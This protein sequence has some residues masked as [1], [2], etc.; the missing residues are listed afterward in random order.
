MRGRWPAFPELWEPVAKAYGGELLI[1][2][3]ASDVVLCGGKD[4]GPELV[5]KAN[6]VM[7]NDERP[8]SATIFRWTPTGWDVVAQPAPISPTKRKRER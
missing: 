7:L 2:V 4:S 1:S 8:L 5:K 3:P 6:E